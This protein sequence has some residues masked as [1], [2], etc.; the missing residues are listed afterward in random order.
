M[1]SGPCLDD[2]GDREDPRSRRQPRGR[3][4]PGPAARACVPQ[5]QRSAHVCGWPG[6]GCACGSGLTNKCR[7]AGE[8]VTRAPLLGA[9]G[10]CGRS[11]ARPRPRG[12]GRGLP[13][14]AQEETA[15]K[16]SSGSAG[17]GLKV[18]FSRVPSQGQGPSSPVSFSRA[19]GAG[20]EL[21]PFE[22]RGG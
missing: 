6:T 21:C 19:S 14:E 10:L 7:R 9:R 20:I 1:Q 13:E 22:L 2:R 4:W 3:E 8:T 15:P 11:A 18:K 5:L 12:V 17:C 16:A